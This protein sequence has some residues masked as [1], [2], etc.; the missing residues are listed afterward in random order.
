[1]N[2]EKKI[3]SE[4]ISNMKYLLGYK[5]GVVISEQ[6][7]PEIGENRKDDEDKSFLKRRLGIIE[8]LIE[9]YIDE[10]EEEETLFSD[11]FEFAS[12]I[13]SWV[14]QDLSMIDGYDDDYDYIENLIKDT[15]GEYILSRYDEPEM[16]WDEDDDD[17]D[18]DD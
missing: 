12:N 9:K 6:E 5:P 17:E 14:T 11:E 10:V 7:Q 16:D 4:E 8:E 3:L 18:D 15:F 1:M 13:I 2:M